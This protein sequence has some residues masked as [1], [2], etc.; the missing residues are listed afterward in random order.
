MFKHLFIYCHIVQKKNM[1]KTALLLGFAASILL[2]FTAQKNNTYT[3]DVNQ[4]S[5]TWI[6]RKV[7]GEHTGKIKIASGKLI[8]D[9]K[10]L[11]GGDFTID[12]TT[13]TCTDLTG[14]YMEKL[15]GHLK[16]DDFFSIEKNPVS[17]FEIT[18]VSKPTKNMATITGN[19]TIKGI[20]KV[21]SFPAFITIK[22]KTLKAEAKKVIVD[23]TQ[24]DIRYGSKSF[25]NLGDKAIDNDFELS[26]NL[27][28]NR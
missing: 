23:R 10:A 21:I 17:K 22:G 24:F 5:I 8:A 14:E 9:A 4:S 11:K 16:S 2:G 3:V 1:K 19:L 13:I 12:M 20:T 6:G 28:A 7:T 27:L 15:L 26:I 25:F 18:N